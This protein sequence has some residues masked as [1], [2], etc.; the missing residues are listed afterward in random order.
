MVAEDE[1]LTAHCPS[2]EG[3][4]Q[5]LMLLH[6]WVTGPNTHAVFGLLVPQHF[7]MFPAKRRIS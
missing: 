7:L 4:M 1:L 6:T 5:L 3:H 2:W